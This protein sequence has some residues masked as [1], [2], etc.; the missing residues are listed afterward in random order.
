MT[1]VRVPACRTGRMVGLAVAGWLV[2][3]G[4]AAAFPLLEPTNADTGATATGGGGELAAPDAQDLRHQ[5][6][7]ANGLAAPPGGGWTIV[8][9]L[10][11]QEALND[12]VFQVH[13]P[14]RADLTTYISPGIAIA[15]ET[16]HLQ[17]TVNYSP[18]LEMFMVNGSQNALTQQLNATGLLTLIPDRLYVDLRAIAGV[19]ATS[20]L[21]GGYGT[22][23]SAGTAAVSL[24]GL[25]G[26]SGNG[27]GLTKS[28]RT[29]TM[30]AG[31][32][33]YVVGR[34]GSYGDYRIGAS[35]DVSHLDNA[36][37]FAVLP[38]AGGGTSPQTLVT[39]QQVAHFSSGDYLTAFQDAVD[40]NFSQSNTTYEQGTNGAIGAA[41]LTGTNASQ[42]ETASDQL[43]W[44]YDQ[45]IALFASLGW[46][47]IRYS[48]S[49]GLNVNDATWSVG[50]TLTPNPDSYL[51]VSY[52]HQQGAD[53]LTVNA[54]YLATART[55]ISANYGSTVGTQLQNLQ[56]QLDLATA[57]GNGGLVNRQTGGPL[58]NSN[59][60]LNVQPGVYRFN[61]LSLNTSTTLDRDNISLGVS[62]TQQSGVGSGQFS[63]TSTTGG[64]ATAQWIHSLTPVMTLSGAL[65]YSRQD[66][67]GGGGLVQSVSASAVLQYILSETLSTSLRYVFSNQMSS[68]PSQSLYQDLLIA[69]FTKQF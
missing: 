30:S 32:S 56:R 69:G 7:L 28:N 36:N 3:A 23:G 39:T 19:Q 17:L 57:N 16:S 63:G 46:E 50:A 44:H 18:T 26:V 60:L 27:L 67:A 20:G 64:T 13:S 6:Q 41:L 31:I 37:G 54:H 47:N 4:G 29:Q 14:R 43:T 62:Y 24:G 42:S 38:L 65:S 25:N 21:L 45:A 55:V 11:V 51:T 59:N 66:Y 49:N 5:L 2:H 58:F 48:G 61:T 10:D 1:G 33:P 52:G 40:V 22:L 8:P 12:N 35:L 15:G 68:V 34:L 9:R 53:S